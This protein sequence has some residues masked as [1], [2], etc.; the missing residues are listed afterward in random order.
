MVSE[1]RRETYRPC[2]LQNLAASSDE[3]HVGDAYSNR[4]RKLKRGA[5]QIYEGKL[6]GAPFDR[7]GIKVGKSPRLV[8]LILIL[9]CL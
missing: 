7:H 8:I 5:N 4:G 2:Y 1:I 6:G 9:I 3:D